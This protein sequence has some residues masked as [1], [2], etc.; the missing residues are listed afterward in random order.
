MAG[1]FIIIIV[2]LYVIVAFGVI[3]FVKQGTFE[4]S[5]LSSL[6]YL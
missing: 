3:G 1:S 2:Y 6:K 4:A 5:H